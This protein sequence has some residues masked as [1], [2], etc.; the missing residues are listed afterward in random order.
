MVSQNWNPGADQAA[1]S[2]GGLTRGGYIFNLPQVMG[3][4][5]FFATVKFMAMCFFKVNKGQRLSADGVSAIR[6]S[7][8][9][10]LKASLD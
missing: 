9:L 2:S 6:E 1:F 8:D 3:R 4:I 5:H 7:L 10:L